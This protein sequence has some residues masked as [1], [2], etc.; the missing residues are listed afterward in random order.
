MD[1]GRLPLA[2]GPA[3]IAYSD[4]ELIQLHQMAALLRLSSLQSAQRSIRLHSAN[5]I[6][7]FRACI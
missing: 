2:L 5:L 1:G 4:G 6:E 3:P 7:V